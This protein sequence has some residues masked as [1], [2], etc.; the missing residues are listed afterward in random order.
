MDLARLPESARKLVCP[1]CRT[2]FDRPLISEAPESRHLR[3]RKKFRP[4]PRQRVSRPRGRAEEPVMAPTAA[5]KPETPPPPVLETAEDLGLVLI[6]EETSPPVSSP[7]SDSFILETEP[8]LLGE[9]TVPWEDTRSSFPV[10]YLVTAAKVLFQPKS[11][12][13]EMSRQA[14]YKLPR[15]FAV[16][17]LFIVGL[18]WAIQ[19]IVTGISY[20]EMPLA[21]M[22]PLLVIPVI[23]LPLVYSILIF[24]EA[25][26]LHL[27]FKIF[28]VGT[29]GY[30]VTFRVLAYSAV[31]KLWLIAP[32]E[33][34]AVA[35]IWTAILYIV[36]LGRAH[37]K[38]LGWAGLV[39][40]ALVAVL[41]VWMVSEFWSYLLY[42]DL[43]N[44]W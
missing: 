42:L 6:E 10:R 28:K 32:K 40:A 44:L 4:S 14:G 26:I 29:S 9:N 31:A 7:E 37:G 38:K 1:R 35:L 13:R 33:W 27:L 20:L 17:T 11:F 5:R 22:I 25:A 36:G 2:M 15:K 12:F 30:Q 39:I 18:A 34:I 41:E 24:I 8:D 3:I 21:G 23:L 43:F 19:F 16:T